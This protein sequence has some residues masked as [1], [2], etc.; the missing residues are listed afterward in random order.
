MFFYIHI[1][2]CLIKVFFFFVNSFSFHSFQYFVW[3][4]F[5]FVCLLS[6]L[7]SEIPEIIDD[8]YL[9]NK[10]LGIMFH[11]PSFFLF[12]TWF[13]IFF[14]N[15]ILWRWC[16]RYYLMWKMSW[17]RRL[18]G[19]WSIHATYNFQVCDWDIFLCFEFLVFFF[20]PWIIM[21]IITFGRIRSGNVVMSYVTPDGSNF[22]KMKLKIFLRNNCS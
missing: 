13:C 14:L 4:M 6:L 17:S 22:L 12:D 9:I 21:F 16:M 3:V 8:M 18:Y 7:R 11:V 20:I 19:F 15:S 2:T 5:F 1:S 10:K